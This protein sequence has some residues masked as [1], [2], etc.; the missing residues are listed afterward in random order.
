M[1]RINGWP[2]GNSGLGLLDTNGLEDWIMEVH[3]HVH[4]NYYVSSFAL[5]HTPDLP[6]S[7]AQPRQQTLRHIALRLRMQC[8]P[9]TPPLP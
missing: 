2:I 9:I 6:G 7:P 1:L 4:V 3:L 8:R 5:S